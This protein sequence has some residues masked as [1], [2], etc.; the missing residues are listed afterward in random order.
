MKNKTNS[1]QGDLGFDFGSWSSELTTCESLPSLTDTGTRKPVRDSAKIANVSVFFSW[2]PKLAL[3][4]IT[5]LELLEKSYRSPTAIP[6]R[7]K[8][9]WK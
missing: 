8:E 9:M 6:F 3:Y 5:V 4:V 1:R 7:D 2:V